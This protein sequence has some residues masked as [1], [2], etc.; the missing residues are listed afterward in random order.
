MKKI[1]LAL[2]VS[3][4]AS[5]PAAAD[6]IGFEFTVDIDSGALVGQTFTGSFSYEETDV[7]GIADE[8]ID[9]LSFD[10]S[11]QGLS[12][13]QNDA[14][15]EAA[16]FNGDFLGLSYSIDFPAPVSFSFTPGFFDVSEAFFAY[17]S[18][19]D[20]GTGSIA[21]TPAPVSVPEPSTLLLLVIGLA[22]LLS[23]RIRMRPGR[24]ELRT[25]AT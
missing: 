19:N 11:F 1:L 12:F 2:L 5:A 21:F 15:A 13:D 16:F 24:D 10:F 23:S 7:A 18:P 6:V 14:V 20:D 22:A 17:E 3:V 9:L 4:L 8:F 25:S